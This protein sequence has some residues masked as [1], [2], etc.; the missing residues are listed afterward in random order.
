[1]GKACFSENNSQTLLFQRKILTTRGETVSYLFAKFRRVSRQ[2]R[3]RRAILVC[4]KKKF[5][6]GSKPLLLP[7]GPSGLMF[8]MYVIGAADQQPASGGVVA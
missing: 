7:P 1:M 3:A 2:I 5:Q 6:C 8:N 4:A